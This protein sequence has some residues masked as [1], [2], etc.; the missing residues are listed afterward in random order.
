M[1]AVVEWSTL[2]LEAL[3]VVAILSGVIVAASAF[4]M[5]L[6]SDG[7]EESYTRLR[8]NLGRGILIGLELLIA[9]DILRSLVISPKLESIGVL[10]GIVLVRTFLSFSLQ[11]EIDGHW[12]WAKTELSATMGA[13]AP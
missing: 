2:A 3:G 5:R 9:A 12:P 4:V 6:A 13:T 7:F 11:V 10:A 8:A 1:S